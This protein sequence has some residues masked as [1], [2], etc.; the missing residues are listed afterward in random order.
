MKS[1]NWFR[2][3]AKD[4][5]HEDGEIEVDGTARISRSNDEGAYVEAWVW[6]PAEKQEL[7]S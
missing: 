6:V 1:D 4:L 2:A 3:Q 7:D 5:Y